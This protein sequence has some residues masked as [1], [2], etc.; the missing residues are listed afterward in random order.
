[1]RVNIS[2]YYPVTLT[3]AQLVKGTC[4]ASMNV[5]RPRLKLAN[6]I[7]PG[8]DLL[9]G[10]EEMKLLSKIAFKLLFFRRRSPLCW[11]LRDKLSSG[12]SIFLFQIAWDSVNYTLSVF[13]W[14][15]MD[16]GKFKVK[17]LNFS[18]LYAF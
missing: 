4:S 10:G 11:S 7:I 1:M 6:L 14:K 9:T 16:G 18:S 8:L 5:N 13:R 2:L 3:E 12:S 15:A 17:A